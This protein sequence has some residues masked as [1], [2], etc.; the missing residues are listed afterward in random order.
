MFSNHGEFTPPLPP[1]P[2]RV[3]TKKQANKENSC[4]PVI[5]KSEPYV[6]PAPKIPTWFKDEKTVLTTP[7]RAL[8]P[9]GMV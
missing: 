5:A 1:V 2:K 8:P 6:L 9:K 7:N 3:A 4:T